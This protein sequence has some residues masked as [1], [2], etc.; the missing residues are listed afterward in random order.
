[1]QPNLTEAYSAISMLTPG[2]RLLAQAW[3]IHLPEIGVEALLT[4]PTASSKRAHEGIINL[5]FGGV[6]YKFLQFVHA[7]WSLHCA[8]QLCQG[9]WSRLLQVCHQGR[10]V[11]LR[12]CC[13]GCNTRLRSAPRSMAF[14]WR[15]LQLHAGQRLDAAT[16]AGFPCKANVAR[17]SMRKKA[18]KWQVVRNPLHH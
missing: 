11:L 15:C 8:A 3:H 17:Q 2:Q 18:C 7:S 12:T 16:N 4:T 9:S 5:K 10:F 14:P 6:L 13:R 1:M